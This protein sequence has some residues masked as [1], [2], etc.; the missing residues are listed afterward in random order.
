[1]VRDGELLNVRNGIATIEQRSRKAHSLRQEST[2][3]LLTNAVSRT[4]TKNAASLVC[5]DGWSA[6]R[7]YWSKAEDSMQGKNSSACAQQRRRS[8]DELPWRP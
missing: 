7:A 2:N 4:E 5:R 1:M 8:V 6:A 3:N